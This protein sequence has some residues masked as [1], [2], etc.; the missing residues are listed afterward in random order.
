VVLR[1]GNAGAWEDN[2]ADRANGTTALIQVMRYIIEVNQ[3]L[4][5]EALQALME[6]EIGPQAKDAVVTAGQ[7]LIEQG[8][9]TVLLRQLRRRFGGEV[10][11]PVEQRVATASI[12]QVELWADR[13]L[14]ASTLAE[15]FAD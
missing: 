14:S 12:E 9:R 2:S 8:E 3:H 5:P 10:D 1:A 11:A 13:V 7:K 15:L 4:Q 6:R